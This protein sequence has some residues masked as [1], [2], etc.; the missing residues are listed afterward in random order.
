VASAA[1]PNSSAA[2]SHSVRA[3]PTAASTEPA[4]AGPSSRPP[5]CAVCCWPSALD[6]AA[7]GTSSVTMLLTAGRISALAS[8]VTASIASTTDSR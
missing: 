5:A 8:T 4:I 7:G 2:C 3:V 6:S 1:A